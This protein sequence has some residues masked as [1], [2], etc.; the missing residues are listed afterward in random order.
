VLDV[1][2]RDGVTERCPKKVLTRNQNIK[3]SFD[4]R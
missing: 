3:R 4:I 1:K 2:H